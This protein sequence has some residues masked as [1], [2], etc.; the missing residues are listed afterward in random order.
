[1]LH[2]ANTNLMTP[3]DQPPCQSPQT[4][5][6]LI[7]QPLR[8]QPPSVDPRYSPPP[9]MARK[10]RL[11]CGSPSPQTLP[12]Y[13]DLRHCY[14]LPW[15]LT[16]SLRLPRLAA[17]FIAAAL[18]YLPPTHC[19]LQTLTCRPATPRDPRCPPT[20]DTLLMA[21]HTLSSTTVPR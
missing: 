4:L 11:P 2:Q 13:Q 18:P 19:L 14:P 1:M 20:L 6:T 16:Y 9:T 21:S 8:H 3:Q 5:T 12:L 7:M 10:Y 17:S 15:P